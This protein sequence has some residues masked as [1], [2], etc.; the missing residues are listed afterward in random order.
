[1]MVAGLKG[2]HYRVNSIKT[3]SA[4]ADGYGG[5]LRVIASRRLMSRTSEHAA[6]SIQD[7]AAYRRIRR[8]GPGET[9]GLN[10]GLTKGLRNG[11][12]AHGPCQRGRVQDH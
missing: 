5:S 11:G 10:E 9:L 3:L 7:H 1:M 4:A 12:G 8:R 2:H 6:A